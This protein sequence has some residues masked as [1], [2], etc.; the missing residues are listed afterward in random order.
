MDRPTPDAVQ[1]PVTRWGLFWRLVGMA[2]ISGLGL[3]SV[4]D[5]RHGAWLAVDIALGVAALVL[6]RWRR[7]WPLPVALLTSALSALSGLAAGPAVLAAVSLATR[8]VYWQVGIV[9]LANIASGQVAHHHA[10]RQR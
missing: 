4:P 3:A 10:A 7:R 5:H 1:P 9:A 2:V 8:R 6:V